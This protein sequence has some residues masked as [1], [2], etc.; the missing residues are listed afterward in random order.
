MVPATA[1]E[2]VHDEHVVC[3]H[4]YKPEDNTPWAYKSEL[5][6]I[7]MFMHIVTTHIEFPIC[8]WQQVRPTRA[9]VSNSMA[10]LLAPGTKPMFVSPKHVCTLGKGSTSFCP[11][12]LSLR[13][14]GFFFPI[15]PC[16]SLT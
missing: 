13:H 1:D 16:Y 2:V 9:D 4:S 5:N 11:Y 8:P 14:V 12:L 6:K 7:R 15:L 10:Q 3:L